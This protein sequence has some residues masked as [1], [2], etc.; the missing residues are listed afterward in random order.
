MA[1]SVPL[2]AASVA[3]TANVKQFLTGSRR[4]RRELTTYRRA[5]RNVAREV[6]KS[7]RSLQA[8]NRDLARNAATTAGLALVVRGVVNDFRAYDR[9]LTRTQALVGLSARS[10]QAFRADLLDL[11]RVSGRGL[12]ELAEGLFFV[13]SA[14][15]R[16]AEAMDVLDASAQAS[17]IGLGEVRDVAETLTGIMAAY[18]GSTKDAAQVTSELV[19]A[20][21]LGRFETTALAQQLPRVTSAAAVLKVETDELLA[22][23]AS[24]TRVQTAEQAATGIRG[25]LSALLKPSTQAEDALNRVGSSVEDL[26]RRVD[27]DFFGA[28]EFLRT[29]LDLFGIDAGKIFRNVEGL[30]ALINLTGKRFDVT[31]EIAEDLARV[32]RDDLAAA[33]R[34]AANSIDQDLARSFNQLEVIGQ[35]LSTQIFPVLVEQLGTITR[36][37]L[38]YIAATKGAALGGAVGR[39]FGPG[40]GLLGSLVGGTTAGVGTFFLLEDTIERLLDTTDIDT[41]AGLRIQ[42]LTDLIGKR[43][44]E[45]EGLSAELATLEGRIET[46]RARQTRGNFLDRLLGTTDFS[47]LEAQAESLRSQI[48]EGTAAIAQ[49]QAA[50]DAL[51][52]RQSQVEAPALGEPRA[53]VE[54]AARVLERQR[55]AFE[56]ERNQRAGLEGLRNLRREIYDSIEDA[57]TA[58]VDQAHLARFHGDALEVEV[59]R[60]QA[61]QRVLGEQRD[62]LRA[63]QDAEATLLSIEEKRARLIDDNLLRYQQFQDAR[64]SGLF[65][66]DELENL[67]AAFEIS[68]GTLREFDKVNAAIADQL[69]R[70]IEELRQSAPE[71]ARLLDEILKLDLQDLAEQSGATRAA[72]DMQQAWEEVGA[73]VRSSMEQNFEAVLTSA[74]DLGDGLKSI[75]REVL[76]AV[77]RSL[78]ISPAVSGIGAF[79][80]IPTFQSG[81]LARGFSVVGERGPELVDF[82]RPGRVYPTEDLQAALGGG[83]GGFSLV[84]N[85]NIESTDGPGV[86]RALQAA[87]PIMVEQAKQAVQ[88]E[89]S[90]RSPMRSTARRNI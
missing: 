30:G 8:L 86:E 49:D 42:Q 57:N 83:G 20:A 75:A 60:R 37:I 69:V 84:Q 11:S 36:L 33:N 6:K 7:R 32:T 73:A 90:R 19:A 12:P 48:Q 61:V 72:E 13:T 16:G 17:V 27:Q 81:G 3:L 54:D 43:T 4:A 9:A 41:R 53:A 31:R 38:A 85:Y 29:Q 44:T 76:A 2:G 77:L 40:A 59:V 26:R 23:F 5:V 74:K 79:L 18:A 21:R 24:L 50:L 39:A 25:L 80:G 62:Q 78:I 55:L 22:A 56:T 63:L 67:R 15:F 70:K 68:A 65:S 47:R 87:A 66:E 10:V 58:L 71:I 1:R 51:Q 88:S 64:E 35:R 82:T 89:L 28:L 14:G 34:I 45:V 52:S 46:L